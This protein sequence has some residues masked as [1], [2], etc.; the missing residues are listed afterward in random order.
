M[1]ASATRVVK[2][3]APSVVTP[4]ARRGGNHLSTDVGGDVSPLGNQHAQRLVRSEAASPLQGALHDETDLDLD[5][6]D[7]ETQQPESD[8]GVSE[9]S[10]AARVAAGDENAPSGNRRRN[11][12]RGGRGRRRASR[13]AADQGS[14][15]H[16]TGRRLLVEVSAKVSPGQMAKSDFLARLREAVTA[17]TTEALRETAWTAEGC[18]LIERWFEHYGHEDAQRVERA[19]RLFAPETAQ[20]AVAEDYIPLLTNRVRGAVANWASTGRVSVPAGF[21]TGLLRLPERTTRGKGTLGELGGLRFKAREGGARLP[22]DPALLQ[23]ELGEGAALD[24]AVR[25]RME[26]A[27]GAD[28]S[29]VRVHTGAAAAHLSDSMNARAFAVGERIAFGSGEYRPGTLVGDALIAHELAHVA[30]QRGATGGSSGP[31]AIQ[32]SVALEQD[33]DRSAAQAMSSL[34]LGA[35][36]RLGALA[37]NSGPRL[38]SGLAVSRCGKSKFPSYSAIVADADVQSATDAAWSST[39][40]ATTATAR[41]EEGFWIRLNTKDGKYEFAGHFTGTP[42]GPAVGAAATPTAKPADTPDTAGPTYTVGLFHTHTPT[43][44]RTVGRGVGPSS[45]DESFHNS[46]DVV[47]VV[48]DYVESPAGSGNIPAGHPLASPATRYH[49]GPDRRQNE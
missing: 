32:A 24:P 45:A 23:S 47:G 19:V 4:S 10:L 22:E 28:F 1:K 8:E 25:S 37:E 16:A 36:T 42:V 6:E 7:E 43:T 21:P 17:A 30:Q 5:P 3:A 9:A 12:D 44:F 18:P 41:R 38:R 14:D 48:Y 35:R 27:Y 49:S 2:A 34:V 31:L 26:S 15:E 39:K 33:A 20:A 46:N 40:A 13:N 29:R 11:D